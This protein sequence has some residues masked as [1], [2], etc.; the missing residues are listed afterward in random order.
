MLGSGKSHT[1]LNLYKCVLVLQQRLLC[2][3]G[4]AVEGRQC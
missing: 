1:G 3:E 2:A 4:Q